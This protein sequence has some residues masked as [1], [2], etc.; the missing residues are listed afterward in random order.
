M[1][2][3]PING[4]DDQSLLDAI[5]YVASGPS[6]LGQPNVG[7]NTSTTGYVTGNY[8]VPYNKTSLC[9]LNTDAIPLG[10]SYWLDDYTWK[11]EFASAQ[12][13]A[14]FAIGNNITIDGVTPSDYDGTYDR[15]GVVYCDENYV[16]VKSSGAYPNP[17][18]TGTGGEAYLAVANFDFPVGD[19]SVLLSTDCNGIISVVGAE[20]FVNLSALISNG[21]IVGS[22]VNPGSNGNFG[23]STQLNRYKAFN[24]GTAANPQY[25]YNFDATVAEQSQTIYLTGGVGQIL[26][27]AID[28]SSGTKADTTGG[29][30]AVIES[31]QMTTT[32]N[33][34]Q[35]AFSI[36][37]TSSG[38]GAYTTSNTSW[39]INNPGN[40]FVD[41][42]L[43]TIPGSELN[44][45]DGVNDLVLKV[46]NAT[47]INTQINI[48]VSAVFTT[49]LDNPEPG[50]YWYI[51]ELAFL[52]QGGGS[53]LVWYVD[54][55]ELGR[56]SLTAQVIKK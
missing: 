32:G 50:L 18:V 37:L 15:T 13:S 17:G 45:T 54:W 41:N 43:I 53:D 55:I 26:T 23:I 28:A 39:T 14:P 30:Y 10:N 49:L 51:V 36:D 16:V 47:T 4:G 27:L 21:T 22:V 19:D 20:D 35:Q 1:S 3:Y 44:G 56:R 38:P 31:Y 11:Y 2:S 5:N 40:Y 48:D 29:F 24:S 33:G 25:F 7:F 9:L 34:I 42:D 46:T 12:P 52:P 6:G 8:R